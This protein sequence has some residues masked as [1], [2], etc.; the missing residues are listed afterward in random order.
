MFN[1]EKCNTQLNI[2][3]DFFPNNVENCRHSNIIKFKGP[4]KCPECLYESLDK[5]REWTS[6]CKICDGQ[7]P[8]PPP[9]VYE[10]DINGNITC[11]MPNSFHDHS[12]CPGSISEDED[13][14]HQIVD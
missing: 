5:S 8:S 14:N 12:S 4:Y 10:R 7:E 11:Y 9:P 1:C 13:E 2:E 6:D 3:E